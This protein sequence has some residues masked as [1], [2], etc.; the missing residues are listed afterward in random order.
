MVEDADGYEIWTEEEFQHSCST[1]VEPSFV[2]ITTTVSAN[3]PQAVVID[4]T[5]RLEEDDGINRKTDAARYTASTEATEATPGIASD[6]D[7][8]LSE[9]PNEQGME[10]T[11]SAKPK[12]HAAYLHSYRLCMTLYFNSY[13][14]CI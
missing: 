5:P 7:T 9:E 11:V 14:C 2:V 12:V 1:N 6:N 4:A 13:N 10:G 8:E 3:E